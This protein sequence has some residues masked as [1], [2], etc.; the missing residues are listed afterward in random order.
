MRDNMLEKIIKLSILSSP[1]LGI[2][3]EDES[4]RARSQI[5][6]L[7]LAPFGSGKSVILRKI[8]QEKLGIQI[9]DYTEAGLIGT[10]TAKGNLLKGSMFR[11]AGKTILVDEFQRIPTEYRDMLL[12]LMEDQY[13]TRSLG[14]EGGTYDETADYHSI[15]V[16]GG[17]IAFHLKASW[18]ISTMQFSRKRIED[19][20]LLSRTYPINM[21]FT[22][23]DAINLYLGKRNL[24]LSNVKKHMD[25]CEKAV[26]TLRDD[27]REYATRELKQS[28][29]EWK[30]VAGFV[31]RMLWDTTRI[32]GVYSCLDETY[33]ITKEHMERALKFAPFE[34]ANYS[35][36]ILTPTELQ[37]FNTVATHDGITPS[38]IQTETEL[39]ERTVIGS[40]EKL[41]KYGLVVSKKYGR[42]AFYYVNIPVEGTR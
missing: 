9:R 20:A 6:V 25:K 31:A 41:K 11:G 8:E 24:H 28:I 35:Q 29:H 30:P 32:A 26:I 12:D 21:T 39:P 38:K 16:R 3:T 23:S 42:E 10:M 14:Y 34:M 40:L 18:I 5:N 27:A 22:I 4:Y 1:T 7:I 2:I 33:E 19:I 17:Y 37:V 13:Y 15:Q 36:V